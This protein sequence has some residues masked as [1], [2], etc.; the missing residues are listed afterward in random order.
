MKERCGVHELNRRCQ[1]HMI[2]ARIAAHA[3]AGERQHGAQ[4]FAA[5]FD[6]MIG[7]LG[8][9]VHIRTHSVPN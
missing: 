5:R 3:R 7:K 1:A 8:N 6:Q 2:A 4:P 9:H